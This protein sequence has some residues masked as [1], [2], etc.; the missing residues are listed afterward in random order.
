MHNL[1]KTTS[2]ATH[3]LDFAKYTDRIMDLVEAQTTM[4]AS[5][6][7]K[8]STYDHKELFM[9]QPLVLVSKAICP[10]VLRAKIALNEKQIP[11]ESKHVDLS[12]KPDWFLSLSPTGKVPLLLVGNQVLFESQVINEYI[13]EVYPQP[14]MHPKDAIQRASHRAWIEF[15]SATIVQNAQMLY[16]KNY[17]GYQRALDTLLVK[18]KRL[19]Q[20]V[21]PSPYY[22]GKMFSLVDAAAAPLFV[23]LKTTGQH[24]E[25]VNLQKFK[26]LQ[27][28]HEAIAD[29]PSVQQAIPNDYADALVAGFQRIGSYF[30]KLT[31]SVCV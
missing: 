6:K 15:I 26:M 27:R 3:D 2:S 10:F 24:E 7:I 29:R 20:S 18:L 17:V 13:E 8:L 14:A 16:A 25:Q 4:Q 1:N 9:T 21:N 11:Y 19:N 28:W 23:M 5:T 31:Q 22:G 30:G 12:N